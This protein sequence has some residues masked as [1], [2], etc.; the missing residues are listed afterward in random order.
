MLPTN[1]PSSACITDT[2]QKSDAGRPIVLLRTHPSGCSIKDE[3]LS[4]SSTQLGT[5]RHTPAQI[6][7]AVA[8]GRWGQAA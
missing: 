4:A 2:R 1:Q 5:A 6:D 7:T 3:L 8:P